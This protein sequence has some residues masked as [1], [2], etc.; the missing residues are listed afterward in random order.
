MRSATQLPRRGLV[1]CSYWLS[2]FLTWWCVCVCCE[3]A[4]A[5]FV[6]VDVNMH[7]CFT[8]KLHNL[9]Y[10]RAYE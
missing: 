1:L 2:E 7:R 6:S 4:V 8:F 9:P 5:V 10:R 3:L